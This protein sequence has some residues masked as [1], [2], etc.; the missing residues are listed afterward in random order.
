MKRGMKIISIDPRITWVGSR[1]GNINV[2]LRPQ[3]DTALALGIINLLFE[4]DTYDH[5][6]VE[7]WCFGWE[8]LK[9]RAAEYPVEKVSEITWVPVETIRKVAEII[10]TV[11]PISWAWGLAFDQNKNGVQLGQAFL[12]LCAMAGSIDTPGGVTLGPPAALLGKWQIGRA[13]V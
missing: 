10:G 5:E 4:N 11:R 13:H 7:N 12:S 3:T 2:Q 1:D 9:E 8:E 6:F